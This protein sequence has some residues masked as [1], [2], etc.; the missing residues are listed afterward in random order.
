MTGARKALKL[1]LDE[2]APEPASIPFLQRGHQVIR[3]REVHDGGASDEL[4]ATTAILNQAV[5]MAVD[6]DM[7]RL[8]RRF[9]ALRRA[10]GSRLWI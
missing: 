4:V 2:G 6:L 10:A 3:H 9:G 1:L 8:V 7:K 5:L